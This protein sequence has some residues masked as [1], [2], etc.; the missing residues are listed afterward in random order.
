MEKRVAHCHEQA[1]LVASGM[2]MKDDERSFLDR[3]MNRLELTE[4]ER[5]QVP[6]FEEAEGAEATMRALPESD[7]QAV[8]DDLVGAALADGKLTPTETALVK[9]IAESLGL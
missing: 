4:K 6:H 9:K 5:D 7:R 1:R 3:A 8:L 2:G